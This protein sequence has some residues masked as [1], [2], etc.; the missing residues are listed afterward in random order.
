MGLL[1]HRNFDHFG[2]HQS[3]STYF[4]VFHRNELIHQIIA[5][6]EAHLD[7]VLGEAVDHAIVVLAFK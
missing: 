4:Q 2:S 1:K 7:V 3:V 6:G 5:V